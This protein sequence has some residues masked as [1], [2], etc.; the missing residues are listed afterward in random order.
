MIKPLVLTDV[1]GTTATISFN[2][3]EKRNAINRELTAAFL[4]ALLDINNNPDIKVIILKGEGKAFCAG[5]DLTGSDSD[6]IPD[7]AVVSSDIDTLQQIT[8]QLLSSNKV[9][10]GAIHGWAVGAGMEWALNCDFTI[11]AQSARAFFPEAQ[12]GLSVTGGVSAILPAIVGPVKAKE[13]ILL[14]EKHDADALHRLGLAWR[15]VADDQ[16]QDETLKLA[17]TLSKLHS[18]SIA[19]LKQG[20]HL[21]V[22]GNLDAVLNNEARAAVAGVCDQSTMDNIKQFS[23]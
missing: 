5:A 17:E 20:I 19:D 4:D 22:Y 3:P 14:G 16:L 13:L 9:V 15:V 23:E 8:R 21:G 2:R 11:W 18:R 1:T 7:K 6:D 12:W 10:I